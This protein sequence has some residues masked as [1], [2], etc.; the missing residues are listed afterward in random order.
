ML[1]HR[2]LSFALRDAFPDVLAGIYTPD[3]MREAADGDMRDVTGKPSF[4]PP[5]QDA[6]TPDAGKEAREKINKLL[7]VKYPD[8][9]FVFTD[10]EINEC[11]ADMNANN[12]GNGGYID[13]LR[14]TYKN[15]ISEGKKRV[16]AWKLA[17]AAAA[18]TKPA[19]APSD[20]FAEERRRII[21]EITGVMEAET[22]DLTKYF[23]DADKERIKV[24]VE[25]CGVTEPG[26][27]LLRTILLDAKALLKKKRDEYIPIPSWDET[28]AKKEPDIF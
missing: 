12:D 19:P 5:R 10:A 28:G 17:Q 21:F 4:T 14:G 1:K 3:E 26:N 25:N 22:P 8:G 23:S 27:R 11:D 24:S 2:A 9:E 18:Q 15:L 16:E 20:A 7:A 13:Y 6:K